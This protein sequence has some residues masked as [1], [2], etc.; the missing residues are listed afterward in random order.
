MLERKNVVHES[1]HLIILPGGVFFF[2]WMN[3]FPNCL[4]CSHTKWKFRFS[5]KKRVLEH[6]SHLLIFSSFNKLLDYRMISTLDFMRLM[7]S[8]SSSRDNFVM[9][10]SFINT[11]HSTIVTHS[12]H[13]CFELLTKPLAVHSELETIN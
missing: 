9:K 11:K 5:G 6:K 13:H 8:L 4:F 1:F 10:L 12:T 7:G 3:D 2:F